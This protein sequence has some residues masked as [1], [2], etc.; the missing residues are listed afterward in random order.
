MRKD[1]KVLSKLPSRE[2]FNTYTAGSF[3]ECAA[4]L[5]FLSGRNRTGTISIYQRDWIYSPDCNSPD[6]KGKGKIWYHWPV[7]FILGTCM[8]NQWLLIKAGPGL[9]LLTLKLRVY[10]YNW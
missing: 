6:R 7:T 9:S 3:Q 4:L 8:G 10:P 1:E 2:N 5:S